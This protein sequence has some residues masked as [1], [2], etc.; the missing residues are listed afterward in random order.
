MG[1]YTEAIAVVERAVL[2]EEKVVGR[3]SPEL[4]GDLKLLAALYKVAGKKIETEELYRKTV[5][6]EMD[7]LRSPGSPGAEPEA[8]YTALE[9][10]AAIYIS[11][12]RWNEAEVVLEKMI[13]IREEINDPENEK[14]SRPLNDLAQVYIQLGRLD[15][16]QTAAKRALKIDER[17]LPR[18]HPELA[19]SL[20]N[21]AT[22]YAYENKYKEA[23]ALYERSL[24]IAEERFG[25]KSPESAA[26]ME[27]MANMYDR[28][29]DKAKANR[30]RK[31]IKEW[32]KAK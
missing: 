3:K 26:I 5:K 14:L 12:Q 17:T 30:T 25:K 20:S 22:V 31:Q 29:G 28:A 13:Q 27:N 4:V 11:D 18:Y 2:L 15:D 1:K 24:S 9:E 10:L 6:I 23:G 32:E 21:L 7:S 16:A 19:K 8:L